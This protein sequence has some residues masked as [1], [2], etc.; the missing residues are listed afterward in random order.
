[1]VAAVLARK[2]PG[3]VPC[4]CRNGHRGATFGARQHSAFVQVGTSKRT[5]RPRVQTTGRRIAE[6]ARRLVPVG[7]SS[8]RGG[9][10]RTALSLRIAPSMKRKTSCRQHGPQVEG[11]AIGVHFVALQI[12]ARISDGRVQRGAVYVR[13]RRQSHFSQHHAVTPKTDAFG[14]DP[15]TNRVASRDRRVLPTRPS[16]RAIRYVERH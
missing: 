11:H 1:M 9:I 14:V 10:R 2:F 3:R 7:C 12:P 13:S 6:E 4:L 15:T 16:I 8:R 5:G